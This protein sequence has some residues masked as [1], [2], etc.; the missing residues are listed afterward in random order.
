VKLSEE[1]A[2]NPFLRAS[3]PALKARIGMADAPDVEVFAEIR[4][5]KDRF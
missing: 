4:R 5:R 2:S 1:L 3:D